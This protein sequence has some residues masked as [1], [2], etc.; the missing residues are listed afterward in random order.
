MRDNVWGSATSKNIQQSD[1]DWLNVDPDQ[2]GSHHIVV[3]YSA[4]N[5]NAASTGN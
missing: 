5:R 1:L 3:F 4:N 2:L